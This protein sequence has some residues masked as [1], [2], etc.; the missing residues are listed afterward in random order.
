M[1]PSLA[2]FIWFILLIALLYFDPARHSTVSAALWIPVIWLSVISSRLPSQW[3]DGHVDQVAQS[4][5]EGNM[6]DRTFFSVLILLAVGVLISRSFRWGAFLTRNI[7]LTAFLL[8]ALVSVCWSDYPFITFK[9]WL[10]DLGNYLV[11]LVVLSDPRP[12]EALS[13]VLRRVCYLLIPLSVLL[14]K[15]YPE[16]GRQYDPWTGVATYAGSTTG[17]N[18]LGVVCLV[19]GLFLFWDTLTR[20]AHRTEQRTK[21]IIIVNIA[22]IAMTLWLL[23]HSN[24][25]TSSVCL[26]VGCL[27]VGAARSTTI[28][29]RP[30]LLTALIP[31]AICVYLGLVFGLG[32]DIKAAV[33][34][35]VGRDPTLTDRT[36]IWD[37]LLSM[38]TNPLIGTGY[39]SF[40]LG[41]RLKWFWQNA[42]LGHINEA[43]NGF[44][45]VYLNLGIVGLILLG[46]FLISSYR[47]VCR[48][49][50]LSNLGPLDLALW[51]VMLLYC[52]TEAGFRTGLM[53]LTFLL[54]AIAIPKR[55]S[56]RDTFMIALRSTTLKK[57]SP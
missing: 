5:E 23:D 36:Q 20:W 30:A 4:L 34:D 2:L 45:E 7:T 43:H 19:S 24:S 12:A 37:F 50:T 38:K 11:V 27:V 44:L 55:A 56:E 13:I 26:V 35:A 29:R 57:Y 22:F 17:K 39:E 51:T 52:V 42:R 3:L 8:F 28:K 48:R 33:A 15:Y 41:P 32:V 54:G 18:M 40:W 16:L 46:F 9:H 25:A 21:R 47:K 10:R 49:L 6:L 31:F 1:P 53:W 14:I